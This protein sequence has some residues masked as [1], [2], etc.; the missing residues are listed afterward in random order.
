M[1]TLHFHSD[2]LQTSD[3]RSAN[4]TFLFWH[5]AILQTPFW[6]SASHF[7]SDI[8]QTSQF[9]SDILLFCKLHTLLFCKLHAFILTVCYSA[10]F[11]LLFWRSAILQ[12][13]TLSF[14]H[15]AVLETLHF[16]SDNLVFTN[17]AKPHFSQ[18][19]ILNIYLLSYHKSVSLMIKTNV[20]DYLTFLAYP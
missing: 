9:H 12:K 4:F 17:F 14:I 2:I 11:T 20:K 15:S 1:R 16:H 13:I 7:P 3:F 10:N 8:L 19:K 6:H 5:S 18:Y